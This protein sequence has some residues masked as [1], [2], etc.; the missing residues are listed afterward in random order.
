MPN[1]A[2]TQDKVSPAKIKAGLNTNLVGSRIYC[3]NEVKS[4]N[5]TAY[6]LA[7]NGAKEGT[8]VFSEAQSKGRGRRGRKWISPK[9]RGIWMSIV[10]R[11]RMSRNEIPKIYIIISLAIADAIKE[12]TGFTVRIKWPNDI[13]FKDKKIGGVLIEP[14]DRKKYIE[15]IIV[16]IGIDVDM[17]KHSFPIYIRGKATSLKEGLKKEIPRLKLL[18]ETLRKIE[19]Y[20]LEFMNALIEFKWQ[21]LSVVV[22]ERVKIKIKNNLLKKMVPAGKTDKVLTVT[23]NKGFLKR[24][25]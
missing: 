17:D 18:K 19:K 11:P 16:G 4:T 7:Q 15:F 10:L 5:D 12:I 14:S 9:G 25:I 13:L 2:S 24:V 6:K 20:Y 21:G 3:F 23:L 1:N 8:V 22:G